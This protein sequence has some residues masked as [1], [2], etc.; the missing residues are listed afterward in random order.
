MIYLFFITFH[1][2][3]LFN[4]PCPTANPASLVSYIWTL[5]CWC[6]EKNTNPISPD[7]KRKVVLQKR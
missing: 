3:Q 1:C 6:Q 4:C 7:H 5:G 2:S